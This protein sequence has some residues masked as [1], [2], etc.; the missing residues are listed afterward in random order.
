[1]AG[2]SPLLE[3]R[4]QPLDGFSSGRP[5]RYYLLNPEDA[6][7][8]GRALAAA[9]TLVSPDL[10]PLPTPLMVRELG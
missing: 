2:S 3:V 1:M 6:E 4:P 10:G 7:H 8:A 9:R 5:R